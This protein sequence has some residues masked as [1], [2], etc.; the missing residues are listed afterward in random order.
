MTHMDHMD[1]EISSFLYTFSYTISSYATRNGG[2]FSNGD[3]YDAAFLGRM[4]YD[5]VDGGDVV[6][7]MV[8]HKQVERWVS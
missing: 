4:A 1:D 7:S 2:T 3:T 5:G 8:F 6:D